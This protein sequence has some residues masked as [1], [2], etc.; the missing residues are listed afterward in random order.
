[1]ADEKSA[2][3][4]L[5]DLQEELRLLKETVFPILADIRSR[6]FVQKQ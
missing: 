2:D 4:R 5:Q 6:L 3:E 1:L